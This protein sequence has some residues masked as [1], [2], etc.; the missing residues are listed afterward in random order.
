MDGYSFVSSDCYE[1]TPKH[2]YTA[3]VQSCVQTPIYS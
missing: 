2:L 3:H 1:E